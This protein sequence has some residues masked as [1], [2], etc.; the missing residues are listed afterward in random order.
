V[1]TYNE[2]QNIEDC[3]RSFSEWAGEVFV[4]DS[5]STD[6][7]LEIARRYTAQV[8]SHPFENYSRQRNWAQDHLPLAFDWVFHI[9]ADERVTPELARSIRA[10]FR[11]GD[12]TE[13]D[14]ILLSRRTV[15]L[16]RPMLHGGHY[17]A[18]HLRLFRRIKGLCEDRRYD[19][20]FLV[21]GATRQVSGD[22]IDTITTDL[23][24]WLVRHA[25][26]GAAE[27]EELQ[28]DGERSN[29]HVPARAT[30]TP[31][32][33]RRWLRKSVYGRAPLFLRAFGYFVYRYVFRLGFLDGIEGLIFHFLQGCCFRFY[34]DAKIYEARLKQA[35]R[36]ASVDLPQVDDAPV[37]GHAVSVSR[38]SAV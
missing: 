26:W 22:L 14:G 25:K 9:D 24:M 3:L 2:E 23:T 21:H 11:D 4:V 19:Q 7:T 6:R 36:T 32:E 27:A 8:C 34:V 15:F 1:L 30:G 18:Y 12:P 33:R 10:F 5:G 37:F 16:G 38:Q 29:R 20:H 13:V 31:I 17:P 35:K 28:E